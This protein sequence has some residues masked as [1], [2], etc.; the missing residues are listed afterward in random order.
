MSR[1][2]ITNLLIYTLYA[3]QFVAYDRAEIWNVH[4]EK[5]LQKQ[6]VTT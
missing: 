6:A 3:N 2:M 1:Q 4:I 5:R